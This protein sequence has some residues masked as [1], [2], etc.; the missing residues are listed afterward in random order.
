MSRRARNRSTSGI[1][2]AMVRGI[3]K[4]P[5][6]NDNQDRW[7]YL[8]VLADAK[9]KTPFRIHA[10][11]L[12][13]NH[14]HLLFQELH[15]PIGN[16]LKRIGSSYVYWYNRKYERV[17]HLFQG[18]FKSE[19]VERDSYF[20]TVL[21]YIH[22]NPVKA[23]IVQNC[24]EYPWSSY[25]VYAGTSQDNAV[26]DIDYS[27]DMMGGRE[28]LLTFINASNQDKC[29]DYDNVISL[30]DSEILMLAENILGGEPIDSIAKMP[31][32]ERNQ[33][34]AQ[35]KAIDGVSARQIARLTG[36]GRWVVDNA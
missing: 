22:Q 3:N 9:E 4:E 18:R 13:G 30:S 15:E 26:V 14:I 7:Y 1:Y 11:C 12:M 16:T 25:S 5:I 36:L 35:L 32:L 20:L 21:R 28:Q 29:L 24:W 10:Y 2:H 17:G 34:L 8:K 6:F 23:K 33:V 19:P 27:I 31:A